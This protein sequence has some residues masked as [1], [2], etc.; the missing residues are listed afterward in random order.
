MINTRASAAMPIVVSRGT[1]ISVS[2]PPVTEG[3]G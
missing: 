2:E 1:P 3:S